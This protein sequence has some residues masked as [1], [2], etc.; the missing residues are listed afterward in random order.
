MWLSDI[1]LRLLRVFK[2]VAEAGGFVN[3]QDQLGISQPAISSHIANLEQRLGVRLCKRGRGGFSLTAAGNEVLAETDTLLSSVE[4]CSKKLST[5]GKKVRLLSRV[6]VVDGI[7]TNPDNPLTACIRN[8]KSAFGD[9]RPRVGIYDQLEC[10]SELHAKRLD[11]C[12]VGIENAHDLSADLDNQHLFDERASL[13]CAPDHACA[14]AA[15]EDDC[16]EELR[17]ARISAHSFANNPIDANLDVILSDENIELIQSNVE[18]TVYLALAGTHI[19]LIPDHL[20]APWVNNGALVPILQERF[21]AISA[22]H[23]LRL[24]NTHP[25]NALDRLWTELREAGRQ[26]SSG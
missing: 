8:S 26:V 1:D 16:L 13:Y 22:F 19:G 7:L 4:N 12:I 25:H 17:S 20:A 18:S 6:G 2:A 15:G 5:I 9:M 3:A 21:G 10:L 23:A 24:K 14:Q 11:I